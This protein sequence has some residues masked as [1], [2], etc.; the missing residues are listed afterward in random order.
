MKKPNLEKTA[1][2]ALLAFLCLQM[3]SCTK[4]KDED[5]LETF[6]NGPQKMAVVG[7]ANN[8]LV[9]PVYNSTAVL[10][11]PLNG[12]V[13]YGKRDATETYW[14]SQFF[15]PELGANV[16][17]IDYA[18]ACYI[19]T[20]W[21][22]L[23]PSPGVYAWRDLNSQI[24]KLINGVKTRGL[25]IAF[26]IV[27][28]GR[29]QGENTPAFVFNAGAGYWLSN[30]AAP[31]QKT[32]YPQDP[33]FRQYYTTFI[34][35]L[36]KDFNDPVRT[37]FIDAYG[38]G[39]W[40][41]A[42]NVVYAEPGTL[43][44]AQTETAKEEVLDWIMALYNRT[45]TKV[46]LVINYH[47]LIGHPTSWG[48]ANANSDRL[49]VKAINQGYS[50]RHDAFGMTDYYQ[51]WEKNF[52]ATW[53]HK[54]PIIMEGGWIVSGT[55]RYWIDS[56]GQYREGHPEDVRLGEFNKSAEAAVNMMD[57]R[58]GE[59][60]SWFQTSF[61]LVQRFN[62]EGGYRLY[63]DE[64]SLPNAIANGA[65]AI[66]SH[67][68]K[69]MGWGYCPNN[70]PQWNYKYKVAFAIL[71]TAGVVK[72]LFIDENGDPSKWLK[73][74]PITYNFTTT[75]INL[76][77]G[78]YKWAVAIVDKTNLNKPGIALAVTGTFKN[79][80]LELG[81]LQVQ[82][83]APVGQTVKLKGP[84]NLFVSGENG[85][86]AMRCN[87]ASA[88]DWETFTIID[89][90]G[91]KVALRSMNK[92]VSSENGATTGI[93]C[94]RTTISDWEKFDW[95]VNANGKISLKGNNGKYISSEGGQSVMKCNRETIAGWEAFVLE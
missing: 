34:E 11:N 57:F 31:T 59:T 65:T 53:K 85:G 91:G 13:M 19:R 87:R 82:A 78:A 1:K 23:N 76:P 90:G 7:A 17:A 43:T 5:L 48:A 42:H 30:P 38:L 15:V 25:P 32:P 55:H 79:G 73:D 14:D 33:I 44:A 8:V 83:E 20:S 93:T 54:R 72:K 12:W 35:E 24:G 71:D 49:L 9:R 66:L 94:N 89:A 3:L 46:P 56:S 68:W 60:T 95:V 74:N 62:A 39:K 41:E 28:D 36:A 70:I 4:S 86:V 45:F 6:N 22:S 16:K 51:S 47:R 21:R 61:P 29:D 18:S 88:S 84:N 2:V 10:R 67:R 26:R 92:F 69:N 81:N 37:S 50:L 64:L 63:P 75:A 40:G 80:W 58:V 77:P 27:V 52:A